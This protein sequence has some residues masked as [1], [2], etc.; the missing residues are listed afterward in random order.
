MRGY[1]RSYGFGGRQTT[2][3]V[4]GLI[5]A[6]AAV[7]A[8]Q[9]VTGGGLMNG[10][11]LVDRWL[12][13]IPGE[14]VGG[15]Q[16][17]RFFSYMFLH[18]GLFHIGMNMFILWMFG[19]Q[20]EAL[21]GRRLFLIYYFVCGVGAAVIYG[22]FNLFG[23]SAWT[24]MLGASGAVYGLLLAYG[25]SFPDNLIYVF[26]ILPIK[27]KYAV[28][29]F[30]LIE[31]LSIPSGG[32]VAH[33][34]HLGGMVTGFLFLQFTAP[35]L[36][37]GARGGMTDVQRQWR[38]FQARN[39]MRVVRPDE[40]PPRGNGQNAGDKDRSPEQACIDE[41]LDK[42]SRNGLQ[43]LTDEEQETLRRAGRR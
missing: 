25:L 8:L 42:I 14:A 35:R 22:L 36:A 43:S 40:Q 38:K 4:K 34:A 29:L 17:W 41:I 12:S 21:W 11:G 32:S 26:M 9:T 18:A 19:S 23:M 1:A 5:I 16:I 39:R 15:L 28:V 37:G 24:P 13:F 10:V 2:S 31:F 3:A 27:A 6:N 7:F 33:L 20:I 30:G